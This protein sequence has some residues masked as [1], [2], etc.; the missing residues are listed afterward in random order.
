MRDELSSNA[1]SPVENVRPIRSRFD[2]FKNNIVS[3]L[4]TFLEKLPEVPVTKDG[5][6]YFSIASYF[7][8]IKSQLD[9]E[10]CKSYYALLK[11]WE[12]SPYNVEQKNA[13]PLKSESGWA[14]LLDEQNLYRIPTST[15]KESKKM[16]HIVDYIAERQ[17]TK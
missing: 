11:E 9:H 6:K 16:K 12:K 5:K 15:L 3:K 1:N 7:F 8:I 4:F 10:F 2:I 17:S 13:S 14:F